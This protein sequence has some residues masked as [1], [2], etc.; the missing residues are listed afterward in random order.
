MGEDREG[1]PVWY[2]NFNLDF[3]GMYYSRG[4]YSNTTYTCMY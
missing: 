4:T 3:K 2:D 1:N